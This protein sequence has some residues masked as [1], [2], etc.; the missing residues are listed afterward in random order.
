MRWLVTI[1]IVLGALLAAALA[2][3]Q[4]FA[5]ADARQLF[6][7]GAHAQGTITEQVGARKSNSRY[8]SYRFSAGT[9]EVTASRRGVPWAAQ[10]LPVGSSLAVRY[11]PRDPSRSITPAELQEAEGW[12]NRLLFPLLCASL[13][14]WAVARILRKPRG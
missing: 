2:L 3:G 11:D 4:H 13:V 12:G 14:A 6:A 9:R 5:L 10:D 1:L 7:T 8:Y